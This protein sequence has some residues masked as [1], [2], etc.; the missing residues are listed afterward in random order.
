MGDK[1][2]EKEMK[3]IDEKI[4]STRPKYTHLFKVAIIL[5]NFL[6]KARWISHL[7]S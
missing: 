7:K 2:F 4:D 3:M 5:T 6:H 1:C